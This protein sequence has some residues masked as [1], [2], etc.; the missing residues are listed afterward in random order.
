[1]LEKHVI[2]PAQVTDVLVDVYDRLGERG[3]ISRGATVKHS[4]R[5][6]EAGCGKEVTTGKT[7]PRF[8]AMVIGS[9]HST[10][11]SFCVANFKR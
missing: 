11:L 9:F 2:R 10:S 5:E 4:A 3:R 6:R 8:V 7:F 1:M